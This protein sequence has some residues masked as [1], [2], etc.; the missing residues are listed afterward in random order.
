VQTA[1]AK[2]EAALRKAK[3]GG[4]KAACRMLSSPGI[5]PL[6]Q[7]TADKLL[8][9]FHTEAQ[10]SLAQKPYL[11]SK[12]LGKK[13]PV[14]TRA[15]LEEAVEHLKDSS[16]PGASAF[17]H[18]HLKCLQHKR[19]AMDVLVRAITG[20]LI[21]SAVAQTE[22]RP[23]ALGETLLKIVDATVKTAVLERVVAAVGTWQCRV[24]GH[25]PQ[26]D[27]GHQEGFCA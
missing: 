25:G 14:I 11:L 5:H 7:A 19:Q 27:V 6:T 10:G 16:H 4:L 17:H 23:L 24:H 1:R 2:F 15:H 21:K 8:A 26:G 9:L 13:V 3:H 18:T 12:A 22:V 20:A